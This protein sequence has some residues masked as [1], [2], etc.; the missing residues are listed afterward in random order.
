MS[1]ILPQGAETNFETK[2]DMKSEV[3]HADANISMTCETEKVIEQS[4]LNGAGSPCK[5]KLAD[6]KGKQIH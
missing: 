3:K 5:E 4:V 6:P 2:N 1:G